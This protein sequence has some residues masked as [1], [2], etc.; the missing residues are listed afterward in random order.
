MLRGDLI[1]LEVCRTYGWT[2]EEYMAQP[3][4]FTELAIEQMSIDNKRQKRA[5]E[6]LQ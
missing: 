4:W 2:Y 3:H 5:R 6:G 1:V